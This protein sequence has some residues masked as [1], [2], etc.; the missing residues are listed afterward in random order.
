MGLNFISTKVNDP[1]HELEQDFLNGVIVE[2]L[3]FEEIS[4]SYII[5]LNKSVS[6]NSIDYPYAILSD[7][8]N[9][10]FEKEKDLSFN[11]YL[12]VNW[13]LDS[14]VL[15]KNLK[16]IGKIKGIISEQKSHTIKAL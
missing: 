6:Y 12:L 15:K 11:C 16:H 5:K 14:E 7:L 1:S 3:M 4:N 10:I 9:S 2:S 8:D 13:E